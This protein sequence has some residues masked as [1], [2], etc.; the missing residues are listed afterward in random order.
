VVGT[1]R[2]RTHTRAE[3]ASCFSTVGAACALRPLRTDSVSRGRFIS[4]VTREMILLSFSL[5]LLFF[6]DC[7]FFRCK[8]VNYRLDFGADLQTGIPQ[9]NQTARVR[10]SSASVLA[11]PPRISPA[12]AAE[13][14][15]NH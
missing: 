12:P 7:T 5:G 14:K 3:R 13:Q 2:A 1:E 15:K 10:V 11:P 6:K 8:S 9:I 4:L